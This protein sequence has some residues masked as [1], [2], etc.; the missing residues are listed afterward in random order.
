MSFVNIL[1][2]FGIVLGLF[3]GVLLLTLKN[4]NRTANRLLG[5]IMIVSSLIVSG[6]GLTKSGLY[7]QI[8]QLI[9]VTSTMIFLLGPLFYLYVK[10]LTDDSYIFQNK[11]YLHFIPYLLLTLY[12][13]PFF[14]KDTQTKLEIYDSDSFSFEHKIIILVQILHAFVYTFFARRFATKHF[15]HN[16]NSMTMTERINLRW[17]K[18]GINLFSVIIYSV[19]VFI[20]LLLLGLKVHPVYSAF[21]P[22]AISFTIVSLGFIGLRQPIIFPPEKELVQSKK[23]E[24][25]TLTDEQAILY[26]DTL[27][28]LMINEK[29]YLKSDVTLQ[30]LAQMLS[31]SPHLL[32]QILN[33][34]VNQNFYDFVNTYRVDEAKQLLSSAKAKHLTILAIAEEAGF[35]SKSSFNSVF[36]KYTGKTPSQFKEEAS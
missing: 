18:T 22:A 3:L 4:R 32:S 7:R 25:S 10:E 6:F 34:K 33:E 27:R 30:K 21:V 23:Y 2:A 20:I 13:L 5:Y 26:L 8:P 28:T 17:I 12:M 9:E 35:N 36:K 15:I 1:M 29:P 14:L 11:E 31:V 16:K 19:P 24:K